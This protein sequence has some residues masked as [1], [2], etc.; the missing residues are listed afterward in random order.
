MRKNDR[1]IIHVLNESNNLNKNEEKNKFG[2]SLISLS[3]NMCTALQLIDFLKHIHRSRLLVREFIKGNITSIENNIIDSIQKD[4]S[5]DR[6]LP[7]KYWFK[8]IIEK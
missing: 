2:D 4:I 8:K 6:I 3:W 1:R 5:D 7:V